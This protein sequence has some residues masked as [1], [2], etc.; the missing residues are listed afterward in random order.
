MSLKYT[1]EGEGLGWDDVNGRFNNQAMVKA[2][3]PNHDFDGKLTSLKA[4]IKL[5]DAYWRDNRKP[6]DNVAID[7]DKQSILTILSQE[8]CSGIRFYFCKKEDNTI[9]LVLVGINGENDL[10]YENGRGTIMPTED[11]ISN[12]LPDEVEIQPTIIMEVGGPKR[13]E[14]FKN[15]EFVSSGFGSSIKDLIEEYGI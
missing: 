1:L 12:S 5:I 10:N 2:N 7:F 14:D 9:S 4:A 11:I 3:T 13:F 15:K 6:E 8:N